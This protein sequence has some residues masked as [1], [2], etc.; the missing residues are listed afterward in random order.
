MEPVFTDWK[1][2]CGQPGQNRPAS[3]SR[4]SSKEASPSRRLPDFTRRSYA[5]VYRRAEIV[6]SAGRGEP[7]IKGMMYNQ[8][9][10]GMYFETT[11]YLAPGTELRLKIR[12][13][14]PAARDMPEEVHRVRVAWSRRLADA[15]RRCFGIGVTLL[16]A[17]MQ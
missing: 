6:F 2:A 16:D 14:D 4:V 11:R 12:Q 8:S 1:E 15:P 7:F 9:A 17:G 3:A 13:T 5:R 10:G